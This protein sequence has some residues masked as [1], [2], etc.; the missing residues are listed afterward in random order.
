MNHVIGRTCAIRERPA[1][2]LATGTSERPRAR[3]RATKHVSGRLHVEPK[4]DPNV[5]SPTHKTCVRSDVRRNR[6]PI[7]SRTCEPTKQTTVRPATSSART[8]PRS[9]R[10]RELCAWAHRVRFHSRG[11]E[12]CSDQRPRCRRSAKRRQT[13]RLYLCNS[14]KVTDLPWQREPILLQ[15]FMNVSSAS[16]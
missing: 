15:V 10:E 5:N 1:V 7:Q 4:P 8:E 14:R 16:H 11:R 2:R 6:S 12:D 9:N 13:P 3:L